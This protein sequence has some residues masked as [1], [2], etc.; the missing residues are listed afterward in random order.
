MDT[1]V[2]DPQDRESVAGFVDK[3][4]EDQ[5]FEAD[6][7]RTFVLLVEVAD[8]YLAQLDADDPI[9]MDRNLITVIQGLG[10]VL[11]ARHDIEPSMFAVTVEYDPPP[12]IRIR[13]YT[14]RGYTSWSRESEAELVERALAG[15]TSA[16]L[17][18]LMGRSVRAI[19]Q[20]LYWLDLRQRNGV[21][22]RKPVNV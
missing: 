19:E 6:H 16:E 5:G 18:E 10:E 8:A 13:P 1:Q 4:N 12:P 3:L 14:V 22:E 2:L 15:A 21:W 7:E 11:E 20:R 9:P 17:A